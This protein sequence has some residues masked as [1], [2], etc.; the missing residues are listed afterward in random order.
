M[1]ECECLPKCPFFNDRMATKP[2]TAQLMKRQYC[3]E[4]NSQCAR[5]MVRKAQGADLVPSDLYPTQI[6]RVKVI[7]EV[8][9]S[10]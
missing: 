7:L 3:L 10:G 2:A 5:Y 6:E 4:D 8:A 1:A 9:R